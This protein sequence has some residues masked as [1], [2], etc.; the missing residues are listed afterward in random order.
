MPKQHPQ[1]FIE[2]W[3]V[4]CVGNKVN[5]NVLEEVPLGMNA[6]IISQN[7]TMATVS[8]LEN[9]YWKKCL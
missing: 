8:A 5:R 3:K 7:G 4:L 9:R 2:M 6:W 1:R